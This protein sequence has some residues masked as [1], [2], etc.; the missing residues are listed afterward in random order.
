M[1]KINDATL[2]PKKEGRAGGREGKRK[3][4]KEEKQSKARHSVTPQQTL[5]YEE[6]ASILLVKLILTQG[7]I[8]KSSLRPSLLGF[9]FF[10]FP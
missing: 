1:S 8:W 10:F 9:W 5:I 6:T 3:G 4:E 2:T 7:L